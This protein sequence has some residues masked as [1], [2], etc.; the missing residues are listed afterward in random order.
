MP[1]SVI[2]LT[3]AYAARLGINAAATG[4]SAYE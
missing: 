2:A 3:A 1:I 4:A